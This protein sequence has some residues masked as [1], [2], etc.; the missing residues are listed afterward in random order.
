VIEP[1]VGFTHFGPVHIAWLILFVIVVTAN[2]IWYPKLDDLGKKRWRRTIACILVGSE[3]T[4]TAILLGLGLFTWDYLPLH[5]CNMNV[6]MILIHAFKPS[7]LLDNFLYMVCIPGALAAILFPSWTELPLL[8]AYHLNSSIVHILL[9]TY[10]VT[11]TVS[12]ELNPRANM[13]LKCLGFLAAMAV[14][15]YGLNLLLDTNFMFLMYAEPGNPLYWF[16]QNWGSH[17]WGFPVIIAGIL[18][19]LYVPMELYHKLKK[20]NPKIS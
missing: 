15:I 19:V 3:L 10:P 7:K 20:K 5:L 4:E 11:L 6:Y 2:C 1:G 8:N 14:P 12:G 16:G 13:I 9:V 17:L 18:I